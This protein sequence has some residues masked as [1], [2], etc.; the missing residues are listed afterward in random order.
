MWPINKADEL[1]LSYMKLAIDEGKKSRPEDSKPRPKVGA[2]VVLKNTV[3]ATAHRGELG[4]GDHAEQT[5]FERKIPR[6]DVREGI[7][8]TTL[9]PCRKDARKKK[10]C[11]EWII[12]REIRHVMIGMLDPNPE[13]YL[14]GVKD[15]RDH[16]IQV[17]FFPDALRKEIE[18]DNYLFISQY[19]ANPALNGEAR[20]NYGDNNGFFTLGH[21]KCEFKTKWTKAS[22][23]AI[24]TY[25]EGN[26]AGLAVALD[27]RDFV[28]IHDAS[29]YDMSSW[30]RTPSTGQLIVLKNTDGYFAALKILEIRDRSRSDPQ[31]QLTL[32]YR[33]LDDKSSDFSVKSI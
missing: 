25:T 23:T 10:P 28:D 27:A 21:G 33:I 26:L 29:I 9:E 11:V 16:A 12:E 30:A 31:D 17:D 7:L 24:H 2:V 22:N 18:A 32:E 1:I 19:H 14:L 13:V 15:L 3:I 20:F 8:F 6:E 5:I 4:A